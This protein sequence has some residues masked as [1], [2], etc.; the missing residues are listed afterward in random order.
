MLKT[1]FDHIRDAGIGEDH[2]DIE[3]LM[4]VRE[5]L[6]QAWRT[7]GHKVRVYVP[8]GP[9]WRAYSQRRLSKNPEMLKHVIF[10]MLRSIV[11]R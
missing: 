11:G 10:G 7:Q 2:Y 6:W 8:Y 5:P 3:V 1:L 9:D 4:G